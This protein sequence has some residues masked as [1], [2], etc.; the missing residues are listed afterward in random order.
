MAS[1]EPELQNYYD[2]YFELFS[3][4][5]WKQLIGELE[6][7]ASLIDSVENTKDVDDMYFRKG[8]LNILNHL[9]NFDSLID[10][11]YDELTQEP[12]DV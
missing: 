3:S 5:G 2:R 12:E 7:N 8:Q 1:I 4:D 11:S 10:N 6:Y 9:I